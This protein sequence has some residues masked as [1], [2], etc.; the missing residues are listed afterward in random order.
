MSELDRIKKLSGILNEEM[1]KGDMHDALGDALT[2]MANANYSVR[3]VSNEI[4]KTLYTDESVQEA[5]GDSAECFYD[6][7]DEYCGEQCPSMPH[8]IL[9]DELVRYLSGDQL[10]DFCDDFRRHHMDG[11]EESKDLNELRKLAGMGT[12]T[13]LPGPDGRF[14]GG[15]PEANDDSP[16]STA[17]REA[18]EETG[19]LADLVTI[20]GYLPPVLTNTNY[21]VDLTIGFCS[22][23]VKE[24]GKLL[25]PAPEEV[26]DAWFQPAYPLVQL[27]QFDQHSLICDGQT[28]QYW[29]VKDSEPMI[30]GATAAMLRQLAIL[31]ARK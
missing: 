7:Q 25:R 6:L 22:Q 18:E 10:Q 1:D 16:A 28:R 5:V 23:P 21:M 17:L 19:L 24:V 3:A 12:G 31:L 4:E 15:K 29:Q 9:I 11:M 2:A 13:D 14:P 26:E 20:Q 8:K 30:W 27:E